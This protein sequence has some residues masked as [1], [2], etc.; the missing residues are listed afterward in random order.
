MAEVFLHHL[1][2]AAEAAG[3]DQHVLGVDDDLGAVL[4]IGDDAGDSVAVGD[5]FLGGGFQHH[6]D[7]GGLDE[8]VVQNVELVGALAGVMR[9]AG[10]GLDDA[11]VVGLVPVA[12][13]LVDHRAAGGENVVNERSV[14]APLTEVHHGAERLVHGVAVAEARLQVGADGGHAGGADGGAAH[15]A[16]LFNHDRVETGFHRFDGG[17]GAR[18]ARADDRQ[19]D[20][21]LFNGVHLFSG[22]GKARQIRA[23]GGQRLLH[24]GEDRLA[25]HGR[26][27]HGIHRDGL[28]RDDGGRDAL[29]T[30][31][32]EARG[33]GA[34]DDLYLE[35]TGFIHGDFHLGRLDDRRGTKALAFDGALRPAAVS[36]AG[37]GARGHLLG[38]AG[39]LSGQGNAAR[40]ERSLRRLQDRGAGHGRAGNAVDLNGVRSDHRARHDFDRA[41]AD[42]GGL[43][44]AFCGHSGERAVFDGERHLNRAA[45]ALGRGLVGL[46]QAGGNQHRQAQNQSDEQREF[47]L[48]GILPFFFREK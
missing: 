43:A 31:L 5:Q 11:R 26:A 34:G 9:L 4:L 8:V 2:V 48:H 30:R 15:L 28:L 41:A 33:I 25:G 16:A 17:H 38:D 35:D 14:R 42:A 46:S 22:L 29:D 18:R 1:V 40:L 27:G 24:A 44:G 20:G 37:V 7:T 39:G 45:K 23:R 47:C 3:A 36:L 6:L 32:D 19:I 10:A 13:N 21:V 12:L